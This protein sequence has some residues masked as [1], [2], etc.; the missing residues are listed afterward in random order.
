MKKKQPTRRKQLGA[1][2]RPASPISPPARPLST[3]DVLAL[4]AMMRKAKSVV[5]SRNAG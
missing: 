5:K 1:S 3:A 2:R 4:V